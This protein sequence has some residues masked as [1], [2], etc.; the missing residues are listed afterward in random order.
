MNGD[1]MDQGLEKAIGKFKEAIK[2]LP[3]DGE[4]RSIYITVGENN[5]GDITVGH[6]ITINT[7]AEPRE[8]ERPLSD[9]E[10]HVI[11]QQA[12]RQQ[13]RAWFR[14]WFNFPVFLMLLVLLAMGGAL[15]SG[16]LWQVATGQYPWI[17]SGFGVAFLL[18]GLWAG[19]I[20]R[21]EKP[22]I[23]EAEETLDY[24]RQMQHRRRVM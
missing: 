10:L 19:K 1:C 15:F 22:I 18:A 7:V 2:D 4:E 24:V 12:K 14:S 6:H 21:L 20:H 3:S 5:D 9:S 8:E 11:K 23:Q 17:V 13:W 16:Y